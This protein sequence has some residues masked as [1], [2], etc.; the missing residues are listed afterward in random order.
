MPPSRSASTANA[1]PDSACPARAESTRKPRSCASSRAPS[2]SVVLPMPVS[3]SMT[4]T[5]GCASVAP[6]KSA[7]ACDSSDRITTP[8]KIPHLTQLANVWPLVTIIYRKSWRIPPRHVDGRGG[9]GFRNLRVSPIPSEGPTYN[10]FLS[11]CSKD[12]NASRGP[13][14]SEDHVVR[15]LCQS[16]G[17]PRRKPVER[18]DLRVPGT[19]LTRSW[20]RPDR[21]SLSSRCPHEGWVSAERRPTV[22]AARAGTGTAPE[23]R[24]PIDVLIGDEVAHDPDR[25]AHEKA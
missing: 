14:Q 2:H 4:S 9:N 6:R 11:R 18:V 5:D 7:T 19:C 16:W 24:D 10:L 3:P 22:D 25:D 23:P 17:K 8:G 1:S 21:R 15:G 12:E 20:H 13:A